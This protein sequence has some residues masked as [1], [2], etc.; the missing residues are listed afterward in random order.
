MSFGDALVEQIPRLRRYALSLTHER[1][2]AAD[3]VQDCL[4]RAVAKQHLWQP[5]TNLRAWLFTILHNQHVNA[6][7]RS[8]RENAMGGEAGEQRLAAIP[9]YRMDPAAGI[10]LSQLRAALAKLP[11]EQQRVIMLCGYHGLDYETAAEYEGVPVGTVRSRLSR[12]R[13][14]LR[15]LYEGCETAEEDLNL[16]DGW[17][18]SRG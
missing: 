4:T 11:V 7:R 9:D 2:R 18:R 8:A 15:Q 6:I 12:G 16:I 14:E 3:L 5:D 1:S 13:E 10:M 17:G